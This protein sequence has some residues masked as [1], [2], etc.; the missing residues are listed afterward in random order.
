[1]GDRELTDMQAAFVEEYLIDLN[2]TQAAIRAGYK[3]A[4]YGRELRTKTHVKEAI[5]RRRAKRQQR[6]EVTQ[7][8]VIEGLLKEARRDGEDSSHGARVGAWKALGK[9]VGMFVEQSE[10]EMTIRIIR[11]ASDG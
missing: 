10:G 9:H 5:A 1:M 6:T 11:D 8:M 3:N 4:S 7:D 2:A